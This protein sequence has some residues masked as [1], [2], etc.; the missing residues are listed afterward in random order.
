MRKAGNGN[1]RKKGRK[2]AY[3]LA[4]LYYRSGGRCKYCGTMTVLD[5][6]GSNRATR[7]HVR[8]RARG[9]RQAGNLVLACALCNEMKGDRPAHTFTSRF[10]SAPPKPSSSG[11]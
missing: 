9:G 1:R 2:P 8:A 5:G 11:L 4:E 10:E 7:D 6:E 3:S